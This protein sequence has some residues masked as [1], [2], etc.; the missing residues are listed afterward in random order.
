M[1][2]SQYYDPMANVPNYIIYLYFIFVF[3]VIFYYFYILWWQHVLIYK[4]NIFCYNS[5]IAYNQ[6]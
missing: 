6:R 1:L 5:R 3:Y 4:V 2:L